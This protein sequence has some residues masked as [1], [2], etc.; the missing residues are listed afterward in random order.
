MHCVSCSQT[1]C[2]VRFSHSKFQV[3][4]QVV[5]KEFKVIPVQDR[6]DSFYQF[7]GKSCHIADAFS[8]KDNNC[9]ANTLSLFQRL[10][11]VHGLSRKF[12]NI[13]NS[14]PLRRPSGARQALLSSNEF[15]ELRRK[16]CIALSCLVIVLCLFMLSQV[17][18]VWRFSREKKMF[19]TSN[20]FV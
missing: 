7:I 6:Q 5:V 18:R 8:T 15:D 20:E 16:N 14:P 3:T 11:H 10:I 4:I 19:F 12:P 2:T 1:V 17:W 13:Q 9:Q